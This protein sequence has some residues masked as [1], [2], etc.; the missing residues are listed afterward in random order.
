MCI[1]SQIGETVIADDCSAKYICP[2]SGQGHIQPMGCLIVETCGVENG[3]RGCYPKQC[4]MGNTGAFTTFQGVVGD[5]TESGMYDLVKTCDDSMTEGWFRIVMD[6]KTCGE[7]GQMSAVGIIAFLDDTTV[8]INS[9]FETSV[10]LLEISQH[11][12]FI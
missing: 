4:I 3:I 6:L 12:H 10:S 11:L 7:T 5:V 1:F 2:K 9:I 8:V